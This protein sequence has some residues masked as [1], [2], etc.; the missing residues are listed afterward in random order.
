MPI[1]GRHE[2]VVKLCLSPACGELVASLYEACINNGL[3]W[4]HVV[5]YVLERFTQTCL[6]IAKQDVYELVTHRGTSRNPSHPEG[7]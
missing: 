6:P 2:L 5:S 1:S 3:G 7:G 4:V